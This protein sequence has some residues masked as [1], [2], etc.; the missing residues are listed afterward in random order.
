MNSIQY[1]LGGSI[2]LFGKILRV[3]L[4]SQ[5]YKVEDLKEEIARKYLGGRGLGVRILYDELPAGT[6]AL[7]PENIMVIASGP[8]TGTKTPSGSRYEVVTKSPLTGTIATSNSGGSWGIHLRRSGYDALVLKGKAKK[9]TY[10]W[11]FNGKVEFKSAEKLWGKVVSEVDTKIRAET[12]DNAKVLQIGIAGEQQTLTAA[13]M[14]EKF[15]A[16]GRG[17]VGAVLGSKNLK[18]IA[19]RGDNK[20]EAKNPDELKKGND[21]ALENMEKCAVTKKD[22]L[23][24]TLGTPVLTNVI[25]DSGIYPTR[26][27]QS[28]VFEHAADISGE[29]MKDT[30]LKKA[31]ACFGCPMFCG[32]WVELEEATFAGK[33]Y[34]KVEGESLEYESSWAFGGQCGINNLNAIAR[35]NYLCNEYGLDTISTGVTIGFAMELFEKELI[36]KEEVKF[37]LSFG[38]ADSMIKMVEQMARR[39]DFGEIL[40]DGS[41]N[42]AKKIG[43][44]SD[45][46]SI[47]VKGMEL[48]AYDPRGCFGIG[49]NYAT[50][51]RGAAHTTGYTIAA[52]I[53]GAPLKVDPLDA[54]I[55]K[56]KLLIFFQDLTAAVDSFGTCLFTTFAV[57]AEEFATMISGA[58]GWTDYTADELIKTGERIYALERLFNKREGFTSADDNLPKRLIE[59]E[60]PDGPMKGKIMPLASMLKMYY[61]QRGYDDNGHPSPSK[62]KELDLVE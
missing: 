9:P 31:K 62:L 16:A 51:N 46:Y 57:G 26:N 59:E 19:V 25:N 29:K 44:D 43:K 21:Q 27:F 61:E 24:H 5:S 30:I 13:I 8:L 36:S 39:Q 41:K 58:M 52:E 50:S 6:D 3:D 33:K 7:S 42:A 45:Y 49:L 53:V 60:M 4:S 32:R 28:G 10:L 1:K 35:A 23:L 48:P 55:E 20:I 38:N 54:S 34:P 11:I 12:H 37:D 56:V 15:R 17:G 2:I 18:A 40:A 14:N 22:G 47:Q